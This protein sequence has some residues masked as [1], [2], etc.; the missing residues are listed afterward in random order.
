M[1]E[2]IK[3]L[4]GSD[5]LREEILADVLTRSVIPA[6]LAQK[7]NPIT[8]WHVGGLRPTDGDVQ[9]LSALILGPDNADAL[10]YIYSLR[11]S[12]VSLDALHLELLEP[13]AR[14]LGELW[15]IDE[16]DFIAVTMGVGRLQRIVHHFAELDQV[17]PY[18]EKRRALIMVAPGEDHDFGSQL[19]QK[20]MKAAGWS[21]VTLSVGESH[22]VVDL[23]AR[24]WL[25]VVGFS[26]S[27]SLHVDALAAL[28][29]SIRAKSLNPNV[30]IMI[31]G[32]IVAE[33]PEIVEQV[34]ADGTAANAVA[35]V[36]L[37]KK[38]LAQSLTVEGPTK[39]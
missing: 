36:I 1:G 22:K 37:A 27:T 18:D 30:G 31:G 8:A 33:M 10:E 21:V 25:A 34:G 14:R 17:Q 15:E 9:K 4:G 6:L 20:F 32:P 13:T 16:V 35:A 7:K 26:I 24:Q 38:I 2:P 5:P 19:V 28:I 39:P 3:A 23:V 12:G 29:K 11:H